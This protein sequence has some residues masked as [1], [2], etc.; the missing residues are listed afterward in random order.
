[1]PRN[2]VVKFVEFGENPESGPAPPYLWSQM[3]D[4]FAKKRCE[5]TQNQ[6]NSFKITQIRPKNSQNRAL[7]SGNRLEHYELRATDLPNKSD[8]V[9][10]TSVQCSRLGRSMVPNRR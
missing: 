6:A 8:E 1:M 9:E 3:R 7:G 2:P 5:I 10:S 4:N